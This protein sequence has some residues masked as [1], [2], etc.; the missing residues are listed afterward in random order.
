MKVTIDIDMT[1][2]ELRQFM[3][4]PDVEK[5]QEQLVKNAE[6]YL[7]DGGAGQ[8]ND[9]ISAAMQPMLAYQQWLGKLMSG[10]SDSGK[11]ASDKGK[12]E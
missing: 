4:L 8:Y 3:G 10:A 12:P 7:K 2:Q 11:A 9:L 1:P 6:Q 5:L